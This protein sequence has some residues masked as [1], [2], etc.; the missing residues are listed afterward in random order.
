MDPEAMTIGELADA[1]N[2][3]RRAIRFYIQQKLLPLPSGRG[4]GSHYQKR[5]LDRLTEIA[6]LQ[7]AGHSL[8]AIRKILGGEP[9]SKPA[10]EI[11]ASQ[12]ARR[13]RLWLRPVA[14]AD[15]WTRVHVAEGIELNFDATRFN[16]S[17]E[18]IGELRDAVRRLLESESGLEQENDHD[19]NNNRP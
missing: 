19:E 7:Q 5:H 11:D 15:L 9:V 4:R 18:R 16:P 8:D 13:R 10:E 2:L 3:S 1:A 14:A 6:R 17:P 12:V